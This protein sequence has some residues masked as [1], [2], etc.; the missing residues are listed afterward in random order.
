MAAAGV[1][2]NRR[3]IRMVGGSPPPLAMATKGYA[4]WPIPMMVGEDAN[5]GKGVV[6]QVVQ[7]GILMSESITFG[8]PACNPEKIALSLT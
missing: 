4:N 2:A 6:V 7:S 1:P 3:M 5:H 8:Q